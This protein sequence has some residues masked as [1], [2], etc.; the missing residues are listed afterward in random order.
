MYAM[1]LLPDAVGGSIISDIDPVSCQIFGHDSKTHTVH[2]VNH[3]SCAEV[4]LWEYTKS[5]CTLD[6]H[7]LWNNWN[8]IN[9]MEVE[10]IIT[11]RLSL[12]QGFLRIGNN[13]SMCPGGTCLRV[14]PIS[15]KMCW[16]SAHSFI[17]TVRA[18]VMASELL[19]IHHHSLGW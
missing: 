14:W 18:T 2:H 11:H 17:F 1:Y 6:P 3:H 16:W 19:G 12:E 15:V 5:T 8:I 4:K 13:A 7:H 10:W 9:A